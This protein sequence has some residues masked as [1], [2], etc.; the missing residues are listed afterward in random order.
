MVSRALLLYRYNSKC[1]IARSGYQNDYFCNGGHIG[2][3]GVPT[4]VITLGVYQVAR[5]GSNSVGVYQVA[6]SG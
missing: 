5:C 2:Q 1:R 4:S 3:Q 6:K